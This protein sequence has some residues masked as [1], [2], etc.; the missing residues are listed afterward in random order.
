MDL[1]SCV[2]DFD[3]ESWAYHDQ[4]EHVVAKGNQLIGKLKLIAR[5]IS[6][7]VCINTL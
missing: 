2:R 6:D 5:D 4:L 7:L 3:A 1:P